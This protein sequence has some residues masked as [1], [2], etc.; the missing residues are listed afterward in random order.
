MSLKRKIISGLASILI[1]SSSFT[2]V[3]AAESS[4][5]P[6]EDVLFKQ[7]KMQK[8]TD[9]ESLF[10]KKS[11]TPTEK[12]VKKNQ[13]L[14]NSIVPQEKLGMKGNSEKMPVV[15]AGWKPG[16]GFGNPTGTNLLPFTNFDNGDIINVHDG[17]VPWGYYRHTGIWDSD[18]YTGSLYDNCIWEANVV[19]ISDV[20]RTTPD[21]FTPPRRTQNVF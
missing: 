4:P 18:F 5:T 9:I 20:H 11:F 21:F 16:D 8:I 6:N 2:P 17:T 14:K 13:E 19:P 10:H 3:W 7:Q 1:V 15:P 12:D